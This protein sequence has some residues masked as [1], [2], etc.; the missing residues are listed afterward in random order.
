MSFRY[1]KIIRF[2]HPRYY[3]KIIGDILKNVPKT[4]ASVLIALHVNDIENEA[5]NLK[6]NHKD[7]I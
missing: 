2:F 5:E 7:A 6:V 4:S 1:L 3:P